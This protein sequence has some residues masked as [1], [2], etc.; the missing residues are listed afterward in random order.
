MPRYKLTLEYD[1]MPY[2]GWQ[3]QADVIS[4]QQALEEAVE[5]FAQ[6]KVTM[7]GA[8]RTDAGVHA[9][10]QVAH[11]DLEKSWK[12]EKIVEAANGLL[13]FKEHPI[14]VVGAELVDEEFDARFSAVQRHYRYRLIN[15]RAPLTVENERAWWVRFPLD[16]EAMHEAAQ[17]LVGRY[18]FSTFRASECQAKSPI[19]T[20]DTFSVSIAEGS[21]AIG[22]EGII[23]N[24]DI[25]SRSF[26]HSQVRSMVG[27]LK[28]VGDGKWTKQDFIDARDAKD[29]KA[30]GVVAPPYGLYLMQV[31]Y[32]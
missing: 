29:R 27:S 26:L 3:R 13:R 24:F 5:Q 19:R 1:G 32:T 11:V 18:D 6:H 23:I 10:G 16:V 7:L 9:V 28:M 21:S 12:T 20:L 8:G 25:S 15:R 4:V 17:E 2:F 31:D 30:C 14:A 22:G